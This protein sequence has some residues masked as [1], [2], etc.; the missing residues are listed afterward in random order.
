MAQIDGVRLVGSGKGMSEAMQS[1]LNLTAVDLRAYLLRWV[2][3]SGQSDV[4][5]GN[6]IEERANSIAAGIVT[7]V[8]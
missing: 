7:K 4:R 1:A 8:N 5:V 2:A 6:V 3:G